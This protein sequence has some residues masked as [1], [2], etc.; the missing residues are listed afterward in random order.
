[1]VMARVINLIDAA[2][3]IYH[4]RI[5]HRRRTRVSQVPLT[6]ACMTPPC[7]SRAHRLR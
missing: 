1:M 7:V 5:R 6:R 4:A 3:R 2:S